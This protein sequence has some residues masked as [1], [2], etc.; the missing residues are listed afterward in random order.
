MPLVIP[1]SSQIPTL[2]GD[3]SSVTHEAL[4][5]L[6][7][8]TIVHEIQRLQDSV[9]RLQDSNRQIEQFVHETGNELGDQ[10][11]TEM[12]NACTDN[13]ATIN[14]QNNIV[15]KLFD[16][17]QEKTGQADGQVHYGLKRPS[18]TAEAA[19]ENAP[20]DSATPMQEESEGIFL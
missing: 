4:R 9:A 1:D 10:D 17:L 15:Q 19:I 8:E 11:R 6:N 7:P 3:Y 5:E 16:V 12:S 13:D 14:K 20:T 18:S 2:V